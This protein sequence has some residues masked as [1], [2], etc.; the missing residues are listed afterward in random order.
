[1]RL[2]RNSGHCAPNTSVDVFLR[3]W[4]LQPHTQTHTHKSISGSTAAAMDYRQQTFLRW[5]ILSLDAPEHK[6]AWFYLWGVTK[7]L[8]VALRQ[9]ASPASD[10]LI[11]FASR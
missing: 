9:K 3:G 1:M 7:S 11:I 4:K 5:R 6:F 8:E 10:H 2:I